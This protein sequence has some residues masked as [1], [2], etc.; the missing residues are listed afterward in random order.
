[1]NLALNLR[2]TYGSLVDTYVDVSTI[3]A[4]T[5]V[6]IRAPAHEDRLQILKRLE[7]QAA[8]DAVVSE[9][10]DVQNPQFKQQVSEQA[11][12]TP[13]VQNPQNKQLMSVPALHT[14]D[15]QVPQNKQPMSE[16]AFDWPDA[17]DPPNKLQMSEQTEQAPHTSAKH[18]SCVSRSALTRME[19]VPKVDWVFHVGTE[20]KRAHHP[21]IMYSF[22][23]SRSNQCYPLALTSSSLKPTK[24]PMGTNSHNFSIC[25]KDVLTGTSQC[26]QL[27]N[28][29]RGQSCLLE[30]FL[31]QFVGC[32]AF[33]LPHFNRNPIYVAYDRVML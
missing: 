12:H 5:P 1:M 14:P 10:P 15:V 11:L 20:E 30:E 24:Q 31:S 29:S 22:V 2:P 19:G 3:W 25:S 21:Q 17:Q 8:P 28:S 6:E 4:N 27:Q 13:D 16:Q 9:S 23:S 7:A 33:C 18:S 32:V 26:G